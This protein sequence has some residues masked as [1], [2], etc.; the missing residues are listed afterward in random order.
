MIEDTSILGPSG[1][2]AGAKCKQPG[3]ESSGSR[4]IPFGPNRIREMV[5][6]IDSLSNAQ[7]R[8]AADGSTAARF[9]RD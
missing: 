3:N 1:T 7:Q 4:S 8:A 9:R 5:N 6:A 2:R